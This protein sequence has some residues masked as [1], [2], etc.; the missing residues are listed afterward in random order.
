MHPLERLVN[1]VALLLESRRPLT[2][3][4]IRNVL[5]AY[6]QDDIAAA[7]RMFERDKDLLRDLGIPVELAPTDAWGVEEGYV[8]PKEGYYLPEISFTPEEISALF[9]AAHTGGED[10]SAEHAVRKLLYGAEGGVLAGLSGGPLAGPEAIDA[11]LTALADAISG[12]RAVRF[13]YRTAGGTPSE[14]RVDPYGLVW[15]G[16][17]WYVVGLDGGRGEIRA[18]RLSRFQGDVAD[19]GEG[20]DPPEGFRASDHVQAGPWGPGE[21]VGRARILLAPQVAWWAVKG[22]QGAEEGKTRKGGW[23]EVTVPTAPGDALASWVLSLGPDARVLSPASL[24]HE[25]VRR[26][27]ATLA[28]L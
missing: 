11:P 12:K 22:I 10:T 1:L 16:G 3:D 4:D 5:P 15:R 17:H 21:P 23:V 6:S 14:R 18:F 26:L 25:V 13:A 20:S 9:V 7:K 27:E 19:V 2:F 8:I 24:R 28:S